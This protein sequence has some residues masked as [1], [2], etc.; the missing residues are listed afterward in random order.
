MAA[1]PTL[2][3]HPFAVGRV[4]YPTEAAALAAVDRAVEVQPHAEYRV[5]DRRTGATLHR[6][7]PACPGCDTALM[8]PAPAGQPGDDSFYCEGC[9]SAWSLTELRPVL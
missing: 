8:G 7:T 5:I 3:S 9:G 6:R 1:A 2:E 4:V